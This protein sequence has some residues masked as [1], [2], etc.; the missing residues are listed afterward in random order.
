MVGNKLKVHDWDTP[1]PHFNNKGTPSPRFSS[2]RYTVKDM[3]S[4]KSGTTY[5]TEAE[6]REA[7]SSIL[8]NVATQDRPNFGGQRPASLVTGPET[9]DDDTVEEKKVSKKKSKKNK[10]GKSKEQPGRSKSFT[11]KLK[12]SVEKA[13]I[14]V[15]NATRK[16]EASRI[17]DKEQD[18]L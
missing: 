12:K 4:P 17:P 7:P 18:T 13:Q 1:S 6:V 14:R 2:N 15:K 5:N 9:V 3:M 8:D 16:V 11:E 10:K